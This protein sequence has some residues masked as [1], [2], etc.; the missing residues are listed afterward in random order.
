MLPARKRTQWFIKCVVCFFLAILF[1]GIMPWLLETAAQ[2]TG[3]PSPLFQKESL[4]A[5]EWHF[6]GWAVLIVA[7][8]TVVAFYASSL[9]RGLLQAVGVALLIGA[10]FC[11]LAVQ[12]APHGYYEDNLLLLLRFGLPALSALLLWLS[13]ANFKRI[14]V[15]RRLWL[16][17]ASVLL[18][19]IIF[20]FGSIIFFSQVLW[21]LFPQN[22][23]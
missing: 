13:Y 22:V 3:A 18:F 17:N 23:L 11:W 5:Y 8:M 21:F 20:V 9:T 2:F 6:L 1:G 4:A 7:I 19:V 10:V 15:G 16:E 14:T 12:M